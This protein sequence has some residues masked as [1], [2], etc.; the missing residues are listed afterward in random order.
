MF[1]PGANSYAQKDVRTKCSG[2]SDVSH[3]T[4]DENGNEVLETGVF[5]PQYGAVAGRAVCTGH[6]SGLPSIVVG[7]AT[8]SRQ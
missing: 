5:H 6:I 8:S 7:P 2:P 4:F 1:G 3:T